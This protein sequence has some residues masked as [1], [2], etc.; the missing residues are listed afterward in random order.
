MRALRELTLML[1]L[2]AVATLPACS[3]RGRNSAGTDPAIVL[4]V[5]NRNWSEVT[6]WVV[7]DGARD[8]LGRV[9]GATRSV[10]RIPGHFIG[11]NGAVRLVAEPQF[12]RSKADMAVTTETLILKSG[13]RVLWTLERELQYSS[14]QIQ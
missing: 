2:I 6:V 5:D 11:Q 7:H 3:K 9:S 1:G 14:V 4:H 12:S 13:I 10:L 8:K